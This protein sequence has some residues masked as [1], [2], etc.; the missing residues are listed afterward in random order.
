MMTSHSKSAN[1]SYTVFTLPLNN[2]KEMNTTE[3]SNKGIYRKTE[4]QQFHEG[5]LSL[6]VR[7]VELSIDEIFYADS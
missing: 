4:L 3:K 7:H 5:K 1:K 6:E 2:V